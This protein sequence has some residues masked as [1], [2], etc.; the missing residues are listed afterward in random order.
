[1]GVAIKDQHC[2][3]NCQLLNHL[4]EI[5]NDFEILLDAQQDDLAVFK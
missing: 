4:A 1:M 5:K 3:F 2:P